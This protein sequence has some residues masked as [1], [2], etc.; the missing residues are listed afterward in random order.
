MK[1]EY[2]LKKRISRYLKKEQLEKGDSFSRLKLPFLRRARKN[3]AVASLIMDISDKDNF[4][5]S[6]KLPYDF[7]AYDWVIVIAYY[8]MYMSALAA[9]AN[10][11]FKSRSHAAT[12]ALLEYGYVLQNKLDVKHLHS[13]S[14]AYLLSEELI[15]KLVQAKTNRETAQY[16]ATPA[17]AQQNAISSLEDADE[18]ITKIEELLQ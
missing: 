13:L 14:N 8:S 3:F 7:E 5:N 9:I 17:I 6:L 16:D 12:V 18:F 2:A 11:S 1:K 15:T 4:K 10:I